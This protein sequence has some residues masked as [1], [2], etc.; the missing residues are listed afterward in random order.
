MKFFSKNELRI[1]WPFYL[2]LV[3]SRSLS[4]V[5]FFFVVY[6]LNSGLTA[7]QVGILVAISPLV[8]FLFEIPTGAI[9]DLY[10]RKFSVLL[11]YFIEGIS[12]LL[13]FFVKDFYALIGV[14]SLLGF[15]VTFSSGAKEAWITDLAGSKNKHLIHDYFS[16]SQ[17]IE[18]IGYILAGLIGAILVKNFGLSIVWPM[19]AISFLTSIILLS[20]AKERYKKKKSHVVQALTDI[21]KQSIVAMCYSKKHHVLPL[22]FVAAS[23]LAF[24]GVLGGQLSVTPYLQGL[25]FQDHWFGYLGTLMSLTMMS[26]ILGRKFYVKNRERQF[27]ITSLTLGALLTLLVI[28]ANNIAFGMAVVLGSMF[29][30]SMTRPVERVF[31]HKYIPSKL[32]ATI[33]SIESMLLAIVGFASV[34]LVGYL[35]DILGGQWTIFISG[36]FVLIGIYLYHKINEVKE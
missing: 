4:L 15:G 30:F 35:V 25:G 6:F 24:A 1:F 2:E 3:I 26:P 34:P 32:R 33:G 16:K 18:S 8:A 5:A 27:I 22:F 13:V 29:F 28:L 7:L 9:A 21:K 36:I 17:I 23:I 14:F 20:W 19:S 11:G 10:G 12:Y 31:F